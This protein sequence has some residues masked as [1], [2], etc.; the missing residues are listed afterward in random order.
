[1]SFLSSNIT[2]PLII[3]HFNFL[4]RS[5]HVPHD[6]SLLSPDNPSITFDENPVSLFVDKSHILNCYIWS[7]PTPV[8]KW[9]RN[10]REL[11]RYGDLNETITI[12]ET[13]K[14]RVTTL[15]L[16]ISEV[17]REHDGHFTCE[18]QNIYNTR[19]RNV[20]ILVSCKPLLIYCRR[21][22]FC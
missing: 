6:P 8:V 20:N 18:A 7:I 15:K 22:T 17:G 1:M 19:R 14:G 2:V 12:S 11:S 16:H 13:G 5:F 10:G 9:K 4:I 3:V 21:E